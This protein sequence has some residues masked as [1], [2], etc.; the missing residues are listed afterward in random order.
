M[1]SLDMVS[2]I[3]RGF[4]AAMVSLMWGRMGAWGQEQTGYDLSTRPTPIKLL[5]FVVSLLNIIQEI[6]ALSKPNGTP[7]GVCGLSNIFTDFLEM[8]APNPEAESDAV[9]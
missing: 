4:V 8:F 6:Y 1:K 5:G 7:P 9:T 3:Y 2:R